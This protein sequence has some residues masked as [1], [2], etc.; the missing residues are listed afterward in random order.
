M[1]AWNGLFSGE[2]VLHVDGHSWLCVGREPATAWN[3]GGVSL[4]LNLGTGQ[5]QRW[6]SPDSIPGSAYEVIPK[7]EGKP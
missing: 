5:V 2:V 6:D 7:P 1:S 3:S 4:M